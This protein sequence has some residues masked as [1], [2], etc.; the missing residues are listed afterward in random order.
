[1][2]Y[3]VFRENKKI[4]R[5]GAESIRKSRINLRKMSKNNTAEKRAYIDEPCL[6]LYY[7]FMQPEGGTNE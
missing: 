6:T 7:F 3:N 2:F 1:M 5:G 4:F